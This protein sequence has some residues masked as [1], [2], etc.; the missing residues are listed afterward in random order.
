MGVILTENNEFIGDT[1]I[2]FA[3][4]DD[5]MVYD[6]GYIIASKHWERLQPKLLRPVKLCL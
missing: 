1:G 3:T 6:L 5:K 4:V 2:M